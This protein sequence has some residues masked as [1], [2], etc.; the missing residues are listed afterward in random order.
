MNLLSS[1]YTKPNTCI[2]FLLVFS[3]LEVG[4]YSVWVQDTESINT[5]WSYQMSSLSSLK[6]VSATKPQSVAPI[7]TRRS[8]L[9]SQLAHQIEL[10]RALSE[11]RQYIP[12]RMKTIKDKASGERRTVETNIRL[13]PMWFT[14]DNKVY[15]QIKYS[16]R[17]IELAKGK[18][19]AEIASPTELI[20]A[21]GVIKQAVD[22]GLLDSQIEQI[23]KSVRA[24]FV[25]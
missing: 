6:L 12:T 9:S 13:K 16:N 5:K 1:I 24:R 20:N 2:F 8:N 18:N 22:G 11:N 10:A 3:I 25:K 17:V 4:I 15:I 14:L 7:I 19:S 23:S 21:L